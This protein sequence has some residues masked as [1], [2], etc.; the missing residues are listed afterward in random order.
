MNGRLLLLVLL[1]APAW[2]AGP[3]FNVLDYGARNDES[4]SATET[5]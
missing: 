2:S 5:I 1:A 3:F 4:A